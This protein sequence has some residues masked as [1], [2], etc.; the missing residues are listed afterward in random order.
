MQFK[1][2]VCLFGIN[3]NMLPSPLFIALTVYHFYPCQD[4]SLSLS[5][6]LFFISANMAFV[7]V[8]VCLVSNLFAFDFVF[9]VFH[10]FFLRVVH[11]AA[12][13][14]APSLSSAY[15]DTKQRMRKVM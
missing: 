1:F 11:S 15:Q 14:Y 12:V 9:L 4:H 8:C 5:L 10:I 7:F 3:F 2:G 6:F 13:K